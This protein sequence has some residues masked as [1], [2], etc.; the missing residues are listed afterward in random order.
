ML[1]R[2]IGIPST[3]TAMGRCAESVEELK[4]ASELDPLS[5][6]INADLG[7]AFYYARQYESSDQA[8]GQNAGKWTPNFW[9]SHINLG[10]SYTQK[11]MHSEANR[12]LQKAQE[13]SLGN[14][15]VMAFLGFAYTASGERDKALR[16]LDELLAQ[17][18]PG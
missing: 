8:G 13:H 2:T 10:R 14:T 17:T 1:R 7:R 11:R 5:L 15:E 12:R 6:V 4:L 16:I 18:Q 9:L 3:L